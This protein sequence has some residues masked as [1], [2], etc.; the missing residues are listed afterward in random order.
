YWEKI[1]RK[2]SI[3]RWPRRQARS[4]RL[5][6]NGCLD[7]SAWNRFNTFAREPSCSCLSRPC[8]AERS[9][10]RTTPYRVYIILSTIGPSL[11]YEGNS[12]R[13]L[14]AHGRPMFLRSGVEQANS[15]QIPIP[16]QYIC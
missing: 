14:G 15:S 13:I 4:S 7:C 16:L 1:N 3:V 11:E 10:S 9:L 12:L 8:D 2:S 5:L 6:Q